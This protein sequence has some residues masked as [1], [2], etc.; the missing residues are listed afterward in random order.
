MLKRVLPN[1][2]INNPEIIGSIP[3][4]AT[5]NLWLTAITLNLKL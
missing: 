1:R 4:F 5:E 2:R 3:V